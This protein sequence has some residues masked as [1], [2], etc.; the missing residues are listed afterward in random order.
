[1]TLGQSSCQEETPPTPVNLSPSMKFW[2]LLALLLLLAGINGADAKTP[3]M[4]LSTTAVQPLIDSFATHDDEGIA[5]DIPN[6]DAFAWLTANVPRFDCP[7][8]DLTRTWWFRWWVYRKHLRHT[9]RRLD[10]H[11]V[12]AGRALGRQ[13]QLHLLRRRASSL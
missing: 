2:P 12:S 13:G 6:R 4:V 8:A 3:F 9:A 5:A 10:R 7:D 11:R 1:M